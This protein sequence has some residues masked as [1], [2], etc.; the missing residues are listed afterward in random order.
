MAADR[1]DARSAA[2]TYDHPATATAAREEVTK[3]DERD[4]EI[5]E[6]LVRRE[7]WPE[8]DDL[9]EDA[10]RQAVSSPGLTR[11]EFV[12]RLREGLSEGGDRG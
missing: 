7:G 10:K 2:S 1:Q 6:K 11:E 5:Y 9:T 4:R 3:T 8:W 12:E